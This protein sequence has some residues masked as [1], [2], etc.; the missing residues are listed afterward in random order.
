M[1]TLNTVQNLDYLGISKNISLTFKLSILSFINPAISSVM[2]PPNKTYLSLLTLP[3]Q[4]FKGP[5]HFGKSWFT[6]QQL[7]ATLLFHG[8]FMKCKPWPFIHHSLDIVHCAV[9]YLFPLMEFL[10]LGNP[11]LIG[12]SLCKTPPCN[13]QG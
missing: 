1:E 5:I 8:P 6:L 12:R 13:P 11:I 10:L 2:Y 4:Y 7:P 3:F 9:L